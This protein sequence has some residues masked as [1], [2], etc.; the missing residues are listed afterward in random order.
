M[1]NALAERVART[2]REIPD[3]PKPGIAFKDITPVLQDGDLFRTII[4]YYAEYYS[5][6][7]ISKIVGIESRGF[8]FGAALAHEMG[9]GLTLIRKPG[10]L[11]YQKYGVDYDLEYGTDRVEIHIDGVQRGEK[12]VLV[13]DLLA[14]GGTAAAACSLLESCGADVQ[15][16]AF[17]IELEFLGGREKLGDHHIH[18]L[19]HVTD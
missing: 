9:I 14:T 18:T 1:K 17:I 6:K 4:N 11:P 10:K 2:V 7:E 8:I 5:D 12:V 13:D 16:I 19:W 3:F 15:E